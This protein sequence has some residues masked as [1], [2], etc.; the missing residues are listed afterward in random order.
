M[1]N[2]ERE[3]HSRAESGSAPVPPFTVYRLPFTLSKA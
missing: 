2:G 3:L 1:V